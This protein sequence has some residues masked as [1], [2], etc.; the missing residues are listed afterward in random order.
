MQTYAAVVFYVYDIAARWLSEILPIAVVA[1]SA[2][3]LEKTILYL[4]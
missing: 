4:V 3:E 2:K 1:E